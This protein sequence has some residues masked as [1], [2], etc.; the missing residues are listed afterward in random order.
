MTHTA[1]PPSAKQRPERTRGA[2][3]AGGVAAGVLAAAGLGAGLGLFL[4]GSSLAPA[5]SDAAS[6]AYFRSELGRYRL[7]STS[8]GGAHSPMM[9]GGGHGWTMGR[10]GYAWMMGGA[11]APAWMRGQD[12]PGFMMGGATDPASVMGRLFADAPGPR[13]RAA[14]A[15]R[16]GGTVPAGATADRATNTLVFTSTPVHLVALASLSMPAESFRIAG[17]T[18]PTVVVPEGATVSIELVNADRDM[19]HG[20]VVTALGAGSSLRP[21]MT[22]PPAFPGAALW[23]LGEASSAGLHEGTLAFTA[24]TPGEYQYLCPVPGH[25]ENGMVGRFVVT[26]N[27]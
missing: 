22:A 21:M 9:G 16:L 18:N 25:A 17:M 11:E 20:L 3:L 2:R 1:S 10:S 4:G 15:K 23:I 24:S 14:D 6:Y 26:A 13:V 7:G 12:L 27:G 19:A 5:T 8:G